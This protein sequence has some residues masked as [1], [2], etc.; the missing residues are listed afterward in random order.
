MADTGKGAAMDYSAMGV[1]IG[2]SRNYIIRLIEQYGGGAAC[3]DFTASDVWIGDWDKPTKTPIPNEYDAAGNKTVTHKRA[4]RVNGTVYAGDV[5]VSGKMSVSKTAEF[6]TNVFIY[7]GLK[8]GSIST[9]S[10]IVCGPLRATSARFSNSAEFRNVVRLYKSV[11][12][13]DPDIDIGGPGSECA[14]SFRDV[15]VRG[16]KRLRSLKFEDSGKSASIDYD[17]LAGVLRSDVPLINPQK[18]LNCYVRSGKL[19]IVGHEQYLSQGL[20]PVLFRYC[21]RKTENNPSHHI[22]DH[23]NREIFKKGYAL[24][25]MDPIRSDLPDVTGTE[26]IQISSNGEITFYDDA[27]RAHIPVLHI[28][29]PT[30][31]NKYWKIGSTRMKI[32]KSRV[33]KLDFAIGFINMNGMKNHYSGMAVLM[34][35]L[36]EFKVQINCADNIKNHELRLRV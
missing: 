31:N 25:K 24:S 29:S 19:F 26:K 35:P 23:S 14:D 1:G 17:S 18:P 36:A 8:C 27:R 34:S 21:S 10:P 9:T 30:A 3:Y 32:R 20:T 11:E 6:L 13:M 22:N 16:I 4:L 28:G 15:Y 33:L 2:L 5:S 7:G 12:A